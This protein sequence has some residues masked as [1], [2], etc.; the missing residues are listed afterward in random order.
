VDTD[1]GVRLVVLSR[2]E[3]LDLRLLDL[4]LPLVQV[5]LE[6]ALDALP[7]PGP[8][9]EGA[10]FLFAV[11]EPLDDVDLSLEMAPLAGEFLATGR[12]RPDGGIRQLLLELGK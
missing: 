1:D 8:L 7:F 3:L 2:E 5:G 4:L 6:V 9:D 10:G 12:V 11:A